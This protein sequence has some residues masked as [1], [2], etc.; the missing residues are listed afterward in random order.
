[1]V[2]VPGSKYIANRVLIGASLAKGTSVIKNVPTNED[3]QI[4]ILGLENFGVQFQ[5]NKNDL[6]IKGVDGNPHPK[7]NSI[8]TAG[9]GTFSRF[10]VPLACLCEKKIQI[11]ANEKMSK[12]PMETIFNAMVSLG[13]TVDFDFKNKVLP[14]SVKGPLI[15]GKCSINASTSSQ[16]LSALILSGGFAKTPI[17]VS[18]QGNLVSKKYIDMTL[19][20]ANHFGANVINEEYEKITIYP[21]EYYCPINFSIE[22]DPASASYFMAMAAISKEKMTISNYNKDSLQGEAQFHKI[23]ERMGCLVEINSNG[24]TVSRHKNSPLKGIDVDMCHMPDVVQTLAICALAAEGKTHI[25]NIAHL[26]YK[27]SDRIKETA[28]ELIKLGAH[29]THTEKDLIIYGPL[30]HTK[31][32][33]PV[34]PKNDHRMAM[35]FSLLCLMQNSVQILNEHCV[36]KSFP[37]YWKILSKLGFSIETIF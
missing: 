30:K 14:A 3:I 26:K 12:R 18:I 21:I 24:I 19:D 28:S 20:I 31:T 37:H 1:M 7:K 13:G 32:N 34:D 15:G 5:K 11:T 16:Y 2:S 9:N 33:H 22:A 36:D 4:A 23:L 29:V 6:F 10:V 25:K 35:S 17:K 27:E 8:Y